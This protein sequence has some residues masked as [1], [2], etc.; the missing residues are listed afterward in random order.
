MAP[1]LGAL[2]VAGAGEST[3][4]EWLDR[5]APTTTDAQ[6]QAYEGMLERVR[7]RGFSV[8]LASDTQL[9]L[10]R[11]YHQYSNTDRA[12]DEVDRIRELAGSVAEHYE[13]ADLNPDHPVAVRMI[14]VPVTDSTGQTRQL[15]S[16]WGLPN[17][18]TG[19]QI[20][21]AATRLQQAALRVGAILSSTAAKG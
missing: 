1:P 16:V 10:E 8:T 13:P 19:K 7:T 15:L 9:E 2:F 6:R 11:V 4:R 14:S 20:E 21:A 12:A 18:L 5:D 3:Q 17:P